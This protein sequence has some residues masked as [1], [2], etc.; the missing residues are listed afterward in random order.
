MRSRT[1]QLYHMATVMYTAA[2]A[3]DVTSEKLEERLSQMEYENR[4]LRQILSLSSSSS[5]S[6]L[7]E[8]KTEISHSV[9]II[10]DSGEITT[11]ETPKDTPTHSDS[12]DSRS[13]TP[14]NIDDR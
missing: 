4:Y 3:E 11:T 10:E 1:D 5:S 2:K 7:R 14:K 6:L 8:N 13:N 9:N 12:E